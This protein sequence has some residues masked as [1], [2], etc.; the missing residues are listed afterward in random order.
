MRSVVSCMMA[1][2]ALGQESFPLTKEC[3]LKSDLVTASG[4]GTSVDDTQNILDADTNSNWRMVS[5]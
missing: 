3:L 1:A 4:G 2:F 5:W